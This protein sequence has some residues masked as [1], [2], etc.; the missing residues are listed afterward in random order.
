ML[1]RVAK[2]A[3]SEPLS[4][5][6]QLSSAGLETMVLDWERWF[7]AGG[8]RSVLLFLHYSR[9]LHVAGSYHCGSGSNC[10][11]TYSSKSK[12]DGEPS[13]PMASW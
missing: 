12:V 3:L 1:A 10:V 9:T 8:N 4:Q 7:A 2:S 5:M 11:A 6:S 13:V